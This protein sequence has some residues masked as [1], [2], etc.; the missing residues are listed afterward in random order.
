VPYSHLWA[1]TASHVSQ[2]ARAR[3][4]PHVTHHHRRRWTKNG[5]VVR[6]VIMAAEMDV[7]VR[8]L[9]AQAQRN[10][11]GGPTVRLNQDPGAILE[12]LRKVPR[13]VCM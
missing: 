6:T 5:H 8:A 4:R 9:L 11:P 12:R 2:G 10:V 3:K 1:P 13:R 7:N